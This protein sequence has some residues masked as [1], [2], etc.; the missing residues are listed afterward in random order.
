M[1]QEKHNVGQDLLCWF[2]PEPSP[3]M[4]V[5]G[6]LET[7]FSSWLREQKEEAN[8]NAFYSFKF[9]ISTVLVFSGVHRRDFL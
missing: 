7:P 8:T 5:C 9:L 3:L 1:G 2:K 4:R 6:D